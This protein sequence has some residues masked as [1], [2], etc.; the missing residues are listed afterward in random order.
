MNLAPIVRNR[1][2]RYDLTVYAENGGRQNLANTSLIIRFKLQP[3]FSDSQASFSLQYGTGLT[4]TDTVNGEIRMVVA[5]A[6]TEALNWTTN[7]LTIPL[8][9]DSVLTDSDGNEW[10]V[11]GLS[12]IL[13][14]VPWG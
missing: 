9:F 7:P 11:K 10:P 4:I 5:A 1:T 12:G 3:Y 2:G 8:Y 13:P 14:V 6:L